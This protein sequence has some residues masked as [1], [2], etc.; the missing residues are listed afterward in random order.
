[1]GIKLDRTK[2]ENPKTIVIDV[3]N[4]AIP[5]VLASI[6]GF[7]VVFNLFKLLLKSINVMY[8]IIYGN[9]HGDCSNCNSH[10]I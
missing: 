7:T 4:I 8:T 2:I 9:T 6:Y 5:T 10:H 1:M 3:F